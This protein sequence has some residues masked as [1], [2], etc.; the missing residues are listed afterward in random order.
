M[1]LYRSQN[2][3]NLK[4]ITCHKIIPNLSKNQSLTQMIGKFVQLQ[5]GK[6]LK[7][8]QKQIGVYM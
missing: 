8:F 1:T 7:K 2:N 4:M 3:P 5:S 6:I